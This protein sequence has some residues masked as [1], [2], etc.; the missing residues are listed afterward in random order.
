LTN[1]ICCDISE[2]MI[3]KGEQGG[4]QDLGGMLRKAI[5]TSGL[6]RN[7]LSELSGVRY[8]P[9]WKFMGDER[10][11]LTL[12]SASKLLAALGLRV[13]LRPAKRKPRGRS[14]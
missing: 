8:A 4:A 11:D 2:N 5:R 1:P 7:A 6:T 12:R 14:K 3:G 10:V 13:E 9:L